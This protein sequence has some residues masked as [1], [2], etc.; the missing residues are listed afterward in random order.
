VG[1]ME[2]QTTIR[3]CRLHHLGASHNSAADAAYLN[4]TYRRLVLETPIPDQDLHRLECV[5]EP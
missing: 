1:E 5:G 4:G 2:H 3:R